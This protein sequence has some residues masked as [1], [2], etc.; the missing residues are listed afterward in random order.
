MGE[1]R[2]RRFV[3]T[4]VDQRALKNVEGMLDSEFMGLGK[5]HCGKDPTVL[6]LY[7]FPHIT[8]AMVKETLDE[9][10]S[11]GALTYVEEVR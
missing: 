1:S 3:V 10:Q 8:D 11:V 6:F 2:R 4:Y 5:V 9:L 7:P